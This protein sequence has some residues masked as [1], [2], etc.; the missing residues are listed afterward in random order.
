MH[1]GRIGPRYSGHR[2][3]SVA[4]NRLQPHLQA[5]ARA[6]HSL[7]QEEAGKVVRDNDTRPVPE[8]LE[9]TLTRAARARS[10]GARR[11]G[12]SSSPSGTSEALRVHGHPIDHEPV[13]PL[14]RKRI[15]DP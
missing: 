7:R 13:N 12:L 14:G 2:H 15:V 6:P 9:Q 1:G 3:Q 8:P 11:G 10:A 4:I 5:I